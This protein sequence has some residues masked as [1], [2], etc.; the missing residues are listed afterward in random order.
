MRITQKEALYDICKGDK[1][2]L[3]AL[4]NANILSLENYPEVTAPP[5]SKPVAHVV[6]FSPLY[7]LAFKRIVADED[8]ARRM[9]LLE[10]ETDLQ[11]LTDK[12]T[13]LE[14]ELLRL[15]SSQLRGGTRTDSLHLSPCP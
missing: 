10:A 14:N 12:M 13:A 3:K 11:V 1:D 8:F 5:G 6:P 15:D 2:S 7:G 9:A 4:I